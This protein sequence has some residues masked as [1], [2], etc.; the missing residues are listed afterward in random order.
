MPSDH[1]TANNA[2]EKDYHDNSVVFYDTEYWTQEGC[3]ARRWRGFNDYPPI[4]VQYAAYRVG[5]SDDLPIIDEIDFLVKPTY[6]GDDVPITDFFVE[7]TGLQKD[8][9]AQGCTMPIAMAQIKD[10]VGSSLCFSYGRDDMATLIQSCFIH[11]VAMPIKEPQGVDIRH[12]IHNAGLSEA[13]L[14]AQSSGTIANHYGI[15]VAEETAVHNAA[16]DTMSL[17]LTARHLLKE[18][19]LN[20]DDFRK[21]H[22]I[23]R[24]V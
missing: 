14:N 18:G 19:A 2:L 10:F 12:M 6:Q 7:L 5:L 3:Q 23:I 20:L 17:I 13:E 24:Q 9:I 15:T 1:D 8:E 11:D 4:L 22:H 21:Q 16:Y